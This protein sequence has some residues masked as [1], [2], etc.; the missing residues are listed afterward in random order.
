MC[1][2]LDKG[3]KRSIA[4]RTVSKKH[5]DWENSLEYINK[6]TKNTVAGRTVSGRKSTVI[7]R[8]DSVKEKK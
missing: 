3:R 2:F 8:T 6:Q 5:Y 1:L 4:G 7:L